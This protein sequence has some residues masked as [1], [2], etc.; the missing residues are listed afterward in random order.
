V[1]WHVDNNDTKEKATKEKASPRAWPTMGMW[2][3]VGTDQAGQGARWADGQERPKFDVWEWGCSFDL[4][5]HP[6]I[7][8]WRSDVY[9]RSKSA[10]V[11]TTVPPKGEPAKYDIIGTSV[12]HSARLALAVKRAKDGTANMKYYDNPSYNYGRGPNGNGVEVIDFWK[13]AD[14][15]GA[16][17]L[18]DAPDGFDS[19][20]W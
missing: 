13:G 14:G 20:K 9:H 10:M 15:K 6:M 4:S 5:L 11:G 17:D 16:D 3:P 12:E 7:I 18:F 19:R 2:S 1:K 8:V